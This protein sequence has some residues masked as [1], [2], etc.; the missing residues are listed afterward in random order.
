MVKCTKQSLH[1]YCSGVCEIF[2]GN[3]ISQKTK[4]FNLIK[5]Q[6][7]RSQKIQKYEMRLLLVNLF[8]LSP[9][10]RVV[11]TLPSMASGAVFDLSDSSL[12]KI[13]QG[14]ITEWSV[15]ALSDA[16]VSLFFSINSNPKI[17]L[18]LNVC[19]EKCFS[20]IICLMLW[21]HRYFDLGSMFL[22]VNPANKR[23]LGGGGADGGI[24]LRVFSL[25]VFHQFHC[26]CVYPL[27]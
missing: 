26:H 1:I 5:M 8:C 16:L 21:L 10:S 6:T 15:D 17:K 9:T 7:Y 19:D 20:F 4:R 12:L 22:Q 23:M 11:L 24:A 18:N 13:V 14:D 27:T 3:S 2:G 25:S